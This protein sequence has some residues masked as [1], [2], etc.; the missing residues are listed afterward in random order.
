MTEKDNKQKWCLDCQSRYRGRFSICRSCYKER[1]RRNLLCAD[2]GS[3]DCIN[4][5]IYAHSTKKKGERKIWPMNKE[6]D[7]RGLTVEDMEAQLP[8]ETKEDEDDS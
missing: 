1:K 3:P 8:I 4:P 7:F 5:I 2:C 6:W